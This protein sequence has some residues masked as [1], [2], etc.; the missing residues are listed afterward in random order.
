VCIHISKGGHGGIEL[1]KNYII[2]KFLS[3]FYFLKLGASNIFE[4]YANNHLIVVFF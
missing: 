2:Y 1:N 4:Q 3:F